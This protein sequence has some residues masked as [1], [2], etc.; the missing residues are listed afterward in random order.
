V[1]QSLIPL[2]YHTVKTKTLHLHSPA[3]YQ[4]AGGVSTQPPP[5]RFRLLHP[6]H[7]SLCFPT[8]TTNGSTLFLTP[9]ALALFSNRTS[10][11]TADSIHHMMMMI[12]AMNMTI[13]CQTTEKRIEWA[14][15]M[16]LARG[17]LLRCGTIDKGVR[18]RAGEV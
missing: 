8:S 17:R 11:T 6:N 10:A 18:G 13:Y 14:R 2:F 1:W 12:T 5:A 4:C 15:R 9:T 7:W 16:V 3:G